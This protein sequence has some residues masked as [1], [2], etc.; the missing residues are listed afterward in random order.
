M[1]CGVEVTESSTNKQHHLSG[2][3]LAYNGGG[4]A[5]IG[6]MVIGGDK[7][8]GKRGDWSDVKTERVS[9]IE[10]ASYSYITK[11]GVILSHFAGFRQ[12]GP[13]KTPTLRSTSTRKCG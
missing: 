5:M 13:L 9:T 3:R 1:H 7:F 4:G 10:N 6:A 11:M 8:S 2:R 12:H